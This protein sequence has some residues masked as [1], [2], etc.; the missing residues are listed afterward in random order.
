MTMPVIDTLALDVDGVLVDVEGS[1]REVLRM[2]VTEMQARAGVV[3]PWTP[4]HDDISAFKRAGGFNDDID[5]SI[6]MTAIALAGK[7]EDIG[8]IAADVERRGGGPHALA[9]LVP[10]LPQ[11]D[12]RMVL[13]LY[14]ERYWGGGQF[15]KR[16]GEQAR[17]IK[18][19]PG[20]RSRE[21]AIATQDFPGRARALGVQQ[22]ALITGRTPLELVAAIELLG[23]SA[24]DVDAVVTGDM[25]RKPDP[26]CF[27]AV[28]DICDAKSIVYIGDTRDD[29]ELVRRYRAERP[30]GA[31]LRGM[32][33]CGGN[34]R[35]I[36]EG[37]GVD[38]VID[39]VEEALAHLTQVPA[40][41]YR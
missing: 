21:R 38:L 10:D 29:W 27:D 3:E 6:A 17:Y 36:W 8:A 39:H 15:L 22:I 13:R 25:V 1:F 24:T 40:S 20:M 7:G 30:G 35:H 23:W 18:I 16:F 26:E 32:I 2:T 14:E 5:L 34:N 4:T 28:I 11:V 12:G 37:L 9:A 41:R 33:V 19:E 31:Q